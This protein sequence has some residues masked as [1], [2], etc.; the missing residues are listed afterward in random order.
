MGY[1]KFAVHFGGT[2][3]HLGG[4]EFLGFRLWHC[5]VYLGGSGCIYFSGTE[6]DFRFLD[7]LNCENV[8][9]SFGAIFS[10]T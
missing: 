7:R 2:E 8:A 4:T 10:S 1:R 6:N 9:E 5:L 3:C